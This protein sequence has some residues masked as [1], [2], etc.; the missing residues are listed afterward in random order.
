[1]SSLKHTVYHA[2]NYCHHCHID[3]TILKQIFWVRKPWICTEEYYCGLE[4][5][6]RGI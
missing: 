1:M 3:L 4:E 6:G 5:K 2:M